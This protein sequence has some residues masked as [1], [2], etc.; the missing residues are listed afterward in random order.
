[1]HGG[2]LVPLDEWRATRPA[3]TAAAG[4]WGSKVGKQYQVHRREYDE[5]ADMWPEYIKRELPRARQ[6]LGGNVISAT[7]QVKREAR[8]LYES[9]WELHGG[10]RR[11]RSIVKMICFAE[12]SAASRVTDRLDRTWIA[13]LVA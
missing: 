1:M 7:H 2:L 3:L 6:M 13:F 12:L 5:K 9:M 8:K 11:S 10:R 4:E